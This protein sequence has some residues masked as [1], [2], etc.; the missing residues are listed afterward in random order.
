MIRVEPVSL[1]NGD[2][3]GMQGPRLALNTASQGP[4]NASRS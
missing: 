3:A 2:E 4:Y 1:L